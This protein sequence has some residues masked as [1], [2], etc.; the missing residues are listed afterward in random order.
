MGGPAD[1]FAGPP[2]YLL[3]FM[4]FL[5]IL[6]IDFTALTAYKVNSYSQL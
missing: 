3:D 6:T 2:M 4:A 5:C 1:T